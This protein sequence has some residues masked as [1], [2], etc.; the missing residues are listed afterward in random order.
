MS[1]LVELIVLLFELFCLLTELLRLL[2]QFQESPLPVIRLSKFSLELLAHLL[3]HLVVIVELI[4]IIDELL[5]ALDCEVL[6][7]LLHVFDFLLVARQL[8][9]HLRHHFVAGLISLLNIVVSA[10]EL[11]GLVLHISH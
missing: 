11:F 6:L 4:E 9:L 5:V 10:V 7:H 2:K 8:L 1:I 3:V